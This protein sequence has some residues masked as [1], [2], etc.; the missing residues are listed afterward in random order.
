[1]RPDLFGARS[2]P[3]A[4]GVVAVLYPSGCGPSPMD[5]WRAG[6]SGAAMP[7]SPG[8]TAKAP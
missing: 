6:S 1:M 7:A 3:G 4:P 8:R 2:D 5:F